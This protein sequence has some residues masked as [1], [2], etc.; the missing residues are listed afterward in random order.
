[1][2]C[3]FGNFTVDVALI[4]SSGQ[5]VAMFQTTCL[6]SGSPF[7]AYRLHYLHFTQLLSRISMPCAGSTCSTNSTEKL[8]VWQYEFQYQVQHQLEVKYQIHPNSR[9]PF[10]T[11]TAFQFHKL[12]SVP[13]PL[14]R[15]DYTKDHQIDVLTAGIC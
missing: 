6:C 5:G 2:T 9:W 11:E 10:P 8:I 4:F 15:L 3:R 13:T 12:E 7:W 1:M 14:V